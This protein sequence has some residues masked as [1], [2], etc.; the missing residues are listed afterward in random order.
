MD[1]IWHACLFTICSYKSHLLL[2]YCYS[3]WLSSP[4]SYHKIIWFY[5]PL[6][7]CKRC[8]NIIIFSGVE[9]Y[10][11]SYH[12][13]WGGWIKSTPF[14]QKFK[15]VTFWLEICVE[16]VD[17]LK[18]VEKNW[19]YILFCM[20]LNKLAFH[21]MKI[22][23]QLVPRSPSYF[24]FGGVQSICL[25]MLL[26]L[27]RIY[28]SNSML[29]QWPLLINPSLISFLKQLLSHRMLCRCFAK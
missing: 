18:N 14:S 26:W 27:L 21:S 11:V 28:E 8:G 20:C 25:W 6:S 5:L 2:T 13:T 7:L 29:T 17:V 23:P 16:S 19:I 3:I 24:C 22:L 15:S 4:H 12:K 1:L 10:F 9:C